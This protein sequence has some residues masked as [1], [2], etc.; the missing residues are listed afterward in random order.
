M[1]LFGRRTAALLAT[2]LLAGCGGQGEGPPPGREARQADPVRSDAVRKPEARLP[3]P[4]DDELLIKAHH[5]LWV[6][7]DLPAARALLRAIEGHATGPRTL[8]AQAS[9]QLAEVAEMTG[10][11][12]GALV[13]LERAK[14]VAGPGHPLA[15]DADDRRARILT[16]TPLADVR[17]PMPGGVVL[18]HEPPAVVARFRHAEQLLAGFHRVVV[19]PQLENINEVLRI[20]RRSLA[21][22]VAAYQKVA[23]SS[24]GAAKAAAL[25]RIGAMYH[26]LAEA[27]AFAIP[28]ELLPSV[29]RQ[30]RRQLQGESTAFLRKSL[31]YYRAA[32]EM[33]PDPGLSPWRQLAAR[34]AKT[35]ALVLKSPARRRA[36]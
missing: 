3:E 22:A 5:L 7:G 23:A 35:L 32:A 26:H 28:A 17:G 27:L 9:L 21:R 24:N 25:F 14:A 19:A 29:A 6:S 30:L 20:K 34:E 16:A 12:R 36:K 11:R 1:E 2:A 15:L 31:T 33:P 18:K 8:R 13:H 10:D 4:G